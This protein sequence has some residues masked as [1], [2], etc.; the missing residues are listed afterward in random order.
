[1]RLAF[2]Q[3]DSHWQKM[4]HIASLNHKNTRCTYEDFYSEHVYFE[5]IQG[6]TALSH[7]IVNISSFFDEQN[8]SIGFFCGAY[9]AK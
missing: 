3:E 4:S 8:V 6:N 2:A 5:L 7:S 1:M 9:G